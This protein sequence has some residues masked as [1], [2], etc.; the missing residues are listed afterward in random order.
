[1][2]VTKPAT[3]R[4]KLPGVGRLGLLDPPAANNLA[5]LGWTDHDDQAHVDLLWSLSRAP[6]PDA[7]LRALVRLSENPNTGWDE[8]NA[9]LLNERS[10]RGRLLAVL[11][12]SLALGD[13]LVANPQSWKLLRGKVILPTRDQLHRAFSECVEQSSI[14]PGSVGNRLRVLYRDHLLV[15]AALDLAPTVED[16]PVL[17]FSLVAAQL[18]DTADAALAAAL[19]VAEATVCG[20]RAPPRLAVIAMGKCGAREL[21][22]VSDVDIIFVG[23]QADPVSTRVAGEMMRFA[24]STFF[25]VDA[26]LRPEGRS[27]ELVRTLESHI[28]YYQ[29][30]AKTWEFQALLKARPAAGDMELGRR[31]VAALMPMVWT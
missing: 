25:E 28:A 10:L 2:G 22:Y 8:L 6:D 27:G 12:S 15:L 14:A 30:W 21:N 9:A 23:E 16:E 3:D 13:H 19:R 4:P 31:Y 18:S 20:D 7:A 29:R 5:Q 26:A 11:G 1:M 24:S 17:P